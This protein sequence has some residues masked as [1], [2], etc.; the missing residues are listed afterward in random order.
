MRSNRRIKPFDNQKFILL[1]I[2]TYSNIENKSIII[3]ITG[4]CCFLSYLDFPML[5]SPETR[6][7]LLFTISMHDPE[8]LN[9]FRNYPQIHFILH[10]KVPLG[11][12]FLTLLEL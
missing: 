1:L 6:F 3:Y 7:Q 9:I 10:Q 5:P 12:Y 11:I 2:G 4:Y 8:I